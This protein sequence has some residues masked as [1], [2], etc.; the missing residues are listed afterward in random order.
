MHFFQ[1]T[2]SRARYKEATH[3]AN[4]T[5]AVVS[6]LVHGDQKKRLT[7]KQ[8]IFTYHELHRERLDPVL[9]AAWDKAKTSPKE[10]MTLAF[11]NNLLRKMLREESDEV[12]KH[13]DEVR[14]NEIQNRLVNDVKEEENVGLLVGEEE[15]PVDEKER[16]KVIRARAE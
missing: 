9:N 1:N 4:T 12:R 5:K 10:K 7:K 11:R 14:E 3:L 6:K 8:A 13:I 2:V 15:L 16:L